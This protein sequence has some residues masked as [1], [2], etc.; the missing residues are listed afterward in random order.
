MSKLQFIGRPYVVFD[1]AN[2]RHR[3]HYAEFQRSRTWGTC[4]VRFILAEDQDNVIAMIQG[5]LTEW[6]TK[7]EFGQITA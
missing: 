1:P 3:A 7:R 6:Y 5:R 2:K 4:P